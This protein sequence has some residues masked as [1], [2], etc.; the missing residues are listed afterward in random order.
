M[1]AEI[2]KRNNRV[3][4]SLGGNI[5]DVKQAFNYSIKLLE[6]NIGELVLSSSLYKT[7]AW[8]VENQPNFLNQVLVFSTE[9]LPIDILH[10]CLET[11]LIIGRVRKEKWHKRLIDIDVLFYDGEIIDTPDLT[12]PHPHVHKRNFVLFPLVDIIPSFRHPLLHKTMKELKN[13]CNDKLEVI[14]MLD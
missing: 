14:K 2:D 7:K 3:V 6:K 10:V 1:V 4:L 12:I 8:G 11:E 13:K 9:L 5:G